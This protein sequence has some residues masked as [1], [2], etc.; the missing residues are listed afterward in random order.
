M[1]MGC[2]ELSFLHCAV[3]ATPEE[4]I[5][6]QRPVLGWGGGG[7]WANKML[8]WLPG[9]GEWSG[10]QLLQHQLDPPISFF[11]PWAGCVFALR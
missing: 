3:G 5:E 10:P 1:A 11:R 4:G 7:G 8:V 2:P 9:L 6:A